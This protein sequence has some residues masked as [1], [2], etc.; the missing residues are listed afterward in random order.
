MNTIYQKT[1]RGG[2]PQINGRKFDSPACELP[3][4][5]ILPFRF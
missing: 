1:P 5:Q 3:N 2:T 4:Q